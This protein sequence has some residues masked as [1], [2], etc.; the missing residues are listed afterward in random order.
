M[1]AP[2]LKLTKLRAPCFGSVDARLR[3]PTRSHTRCLLDQSDFHKYIAQMIPAVLRH[4]LPILLLIP[5][6]L[7]GGGLLVRV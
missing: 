3:E 7:D 5:T 1:K 4:R 2:S 6:Q